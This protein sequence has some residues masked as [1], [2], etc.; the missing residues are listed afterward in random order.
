MRRLVLIM[1]CLLLT[2][3][4]PAC[5]LLNYAEI[6]EP[7]ATTDATTDTV[8]TPT[9]VTL[10]FTVQGYVTGQA[11]TDFY[12]LQ[13]V[14]VTTG[15][16]E[17]TSTTAVGD[18]WQNLSYD[19][20]LWDT[21]AAATNA[22]NGITTLTIGSDL[23]DWWEDYHIRPEV[24]S[25]QTV[26]QS[27]GYGD[28]IQGFDVFGTLQW[29]GRIQS[30]A[31]VSTSQLT[32]DVLSSNTL[33]VAGQDIRIQRSVVFGTDVGG[34]YS[35][36]AVRSFSANL[37]PRLAFDS[38][39]LKV[40]SRYLIRLIGKGLDGSILGDAT[41]SGPITSEGGGFWAD[42]HVLYIHVTGR[43]PQ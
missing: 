6:V 40:G 41:Q 7:N 24:S 39:T 37:S 3:N 12:A 34:P 27:L 11:G 17:G 15:T 1:S 16:W 14:E 32:L 35:G 23:T 33:P 36:A 38:P 22:A 19:S 26:Y 28:V 18:Q 29:S 21:I 13:Y 2:A 20:Y 31:T 10:P 42:K 30:I 8:S 25:S 5:Y 43:K 4:A 9:L